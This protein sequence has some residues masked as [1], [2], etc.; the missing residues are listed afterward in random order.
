MRCDRDER[1]VCVCAFLC[2]CACVTYDHDTRTSAQVRRS[3]ASY[4]H[5]TNSS[6][7][8]FGRVVACGSQALK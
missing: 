1:V 7:Q 5:D 8:V 4:D 2:A 6:M 3:D